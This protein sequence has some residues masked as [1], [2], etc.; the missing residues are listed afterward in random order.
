M[1]YDKEIQD[2]TNQSF[3]SNA[4]VIAGDISS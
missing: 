4:C 1:D 3:R 2:K